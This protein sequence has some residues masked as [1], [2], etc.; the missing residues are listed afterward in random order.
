MLLLVLVAI[1]VLATAVL[2]G[3][4]YTLLVGFEVLQLA[5]LAQAWGLLAGYGGVVSLAVSGLV[6]VGAYTTAELSEAIGLGEVPSIL[7]AGAVSGLFAAAVSVPMFRFR[8][9]YF[10]IASL[11]LAQALAIFMSN[12]KVFGGNQG[13]V[14]SGRSPDA[15]VIYLYALAVAGLAAGVTF[16]ASRGKLGLGLRAIRDDEDVAGRMGVPA[17]RVK[18]AGFIFGA[19]IMGLV[20]GIQAVRVGYVEPGAAFSFNWTIETVNA[21]IIGGAGTVLGPLVGSAIS[22]ALNE[23]LGEYAQLHL[24]IIGAILILVIRV[25]P[26][27]V[28]GLVSTVASRVRRSRDG[29]RAAGLVPVPSG[30]VEN[31]PAPTGDIVLSIVDA[32]KHYG[33]VPAVD[34]VSLQVR[35]GEVLGIVG[36]NGA[37]KST[38]IGLLSGAISGSGT[39]HYL[40]ADV[41]QLGAR[42]RAL[43]GIGRTHQVPRP[44]EKLTVLENLL[45]ARQYGQRSHRTRAVPECLAIL[46]RCGLLESAHTLA[47]ELGLLRLK[48]LELARALALQ[49]RVLLLDEIGAG[50]VESELN[51]LID[52]ITN[53]RRDIEAIVIVE[54]VMDLI[55]RC[56]DRLVVLDRGRLLLEETPE[57]ALADPRVSAV[58]L[59]ESTAA[60]SVGRPHR[61]RSEPL[62]ELRQVSAQYG[63]HHAIQDVTLTVG[64]GEIVALLGANGAGKS[65]VARTISGTLPAAS[66]TI[67]FD[68]RQIDGRPPHEL[69]RAGIAHCMEGRRIFADLTVAE[70]LLLGGRGVASRERTRRMGY[71]HELFP[72]LR[73]RAKNSGA[74]LSGGQQQMLAIGRALMSAPTLVIFDEISLGL[75]PITVDRL[76][77]ALGTI[78]DTGVS[79][80][81]I[82]QNVARGLA[83][84]DRV[85][86]LEKG[87]VALVG[88]PDEVRTNPKLGTLYVGQ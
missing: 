36:P 34:G 68:G 9:L 46:D 80:I 21:G 56:C 20:G 27:G 74:E 5:A 15:S 54:H 73:E 86:V 24:L 53:L 83:L 43:R 85:V 42:G 78:N 19:V 59:G 39:V 69:V 66:G 41:T 47:S 57:V 37:G 10:T 65:T 17:F 79:M 75:A 77:E 30:R 49:P 4:S 22:V 25:A 72:D 50:L 61:A 33:G 55:R 12:S 87:T 76:Y 40:G 23:T 31:G 67:W 2:W 44:F 51:E 60:A 16:W 48:R 13:I 64:K 35:S 29:G 8:G 52:L 32:A 11:V 71:V 45:V 1:A 18:L 38:L 84:A 81:V 28:S 26:N 70:N 6:G 88:S 14:L 62:L 7:A 82:E 3:D 58:Y 63:H